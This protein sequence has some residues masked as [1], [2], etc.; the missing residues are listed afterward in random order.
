MVPLMNL[1]IEDGTKFSKV[2]PKLMGSAG[3][4]LQ[5]AMLSLP[6]GKIEWDFAAAAPSAAA[7]GGLYSQGKGS[8]EDPQMFS[9]GGGG[10]RRKAAPGS[11]GKPNNKKVPLAPRSTNK[12]R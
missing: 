3:E 6:G 4:A 8:Q 1:Y 11:N 5:V 7:A 9:Q 10:G 2:A 12:L